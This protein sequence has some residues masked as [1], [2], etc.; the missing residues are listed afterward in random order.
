MAFILPKSN[1]SGT[2]K[3]SIAFM[4]A[5]MRICATEQSLDLIGL[6]IQTAIN[7]SKIPIAFVKST[8]CVEPNMLAT[9][10]WWLGTRFNIL[11]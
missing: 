1:K 9:I 3:N 5:I 7:I 2:R 10:C 8:A 11:Q 4:A 6:K